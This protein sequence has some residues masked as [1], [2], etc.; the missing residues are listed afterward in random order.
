MTAEPLTR[1]SRVS[2][3]RVLPVLLQAIPLLGAGCLLTVGLDGRDNLL[4][5]CLSLLGVVLLLPWGIGYWY[6]QRDWR[7]LI[8]SFIVGPW[9][10]GLLLLAAGWG[11]PLTALRAGPHPFRLLVL[12]ALLTVVDA[13]RLAAGAPAAEHTSRPAGRPRGQ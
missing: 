2:R 8:T 13:W 5:F 4:T 9:L 12:V 11:V 6:L 7:C 3:R 1:F 10:L